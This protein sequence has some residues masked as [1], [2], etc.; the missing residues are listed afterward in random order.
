MVYCVVPSTVTAR[1]RRSIE[2]GLSGRQGLEV[3]LDG[4]EGERRATGERR[5]RAELRE[6]WSERRQVRYPDGRRVADRRAV[7]VPVAPPADLP[8]ATRA[9][10]S[11]VAFMEPLEVPGDLRADVEA[12]R[13]IVRFQS[14]ER[15]LAELYSR[16]VDPVYTYLSIALD[17]GADVESLVSTVLAEALRDARESAPGPGEVRQWLFGIAHRCARPVSPDRPRATRG[18]NPAAEA[19]GKVKTSLDW[20]SD[21]DLVLLIERRPPA[22]RHLLVLRYF[23]GLSLSQVAEVMGVAVAD[24]AALHGSAIRALEESLSAV[25]RSPRVEGRHPMGRL[26][27]QTP[28]LHQRRR[29]LLAV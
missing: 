21:D 20:I 23:A 12:V 1:V 22:E 3:V 25:T 8:R 15:D 24:A 14:G 10:V 9:H 28:V 7:L 29:A 27:H 13:A 5:A 11:S 2:R 19:G 26:S 16:W 4:R 17:R 18:G 6:P